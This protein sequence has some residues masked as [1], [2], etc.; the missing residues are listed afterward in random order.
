MA[1]TKSIVDLMGGRIQVKSELNKGS[2]FEVV[3]PF[4][5]DP[6]GS[7]EKNGK[8]LHQEGEKVSVLKGM[9]FLCAE[10]NEL[11]AEILEAI[12]KCTRHPA[13]SA[14]TVKNWLKP[15]KLLLSEI[16]ML[17]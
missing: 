1:I 3:L 8:Y 10:D 12:L 15:L 4:A 2:C 16:M 17:F 5:I 13:R 6:N 9:K 14:Q 11:N 7:Q